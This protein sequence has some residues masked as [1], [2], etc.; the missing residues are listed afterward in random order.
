MAEQR[1][2]YEVLNV[3]KDASADDIKRAY[4]RQALKYHPDKNP[5][6]QEAEAKFKEAAEAYEVLSDTTKRQLYDRHGHAGL[7]GQSMHDFSHMDINDIFSTHGLGD[8]LDEFFGGAFGGSRRRGG[9]QRQARG[10]DLRTDIE[11]TLEDVA[12]GI[13]H[14]I[15][16][17]RKDVCET[18][19]GDGGKPGT[20]PVAC[21]MCGGAGVISKGTAI[22]QIRHACP[23][24][25]GAGKSFAEKCP[26]CRGAG[27]MPKDRRLS[28]RIPAG[29]H[30]GQ[31]VRVQ[32]EGEPPP[33][34]TQ[35]QRGDLHVVVSVKPHDMFQREGDHLIL[36]LPTSFAQAALGATIDVPTLDEGMTELTIKPGT[37]H[38]DIHRMPGKGLPSLRT[39]RRGDLVIVTLIE[40]PRKLTDEQK[41]LLRAYAETEDLDVLPESKGFWAKLKESLS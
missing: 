2:Y 15:E 16:F 32:G 38:G 14:E 12:T 23:Q 1:D 27:Q 29:I 26:A 4:R 41:D 13:E 10:Y 40:V 19:T 8:I 11:V 21:V 25:G 36:K 24:C 28:V 18:C 17:T 7:R 3:A 34:P 9:R 39:G 30:D 22:F 20:Q 6:N 33:G 35:G 31:A 37:Q 5:D